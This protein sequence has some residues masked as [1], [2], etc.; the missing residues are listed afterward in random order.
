MSDLILFDVIRVFTTP[1]ERSNA[2]LRAIEENPANAAPLPKPGEAPSEKELPLAKYKMWQTGKRLRINF[3]GGNSRVKERLIE[4]ANEWTEYANLHFDFGEHEQSEIRISFTNTGSWSYIG[5][6]ALLIPQSQATMNFGWLRPD[7]PD[8]TYSQ[9]VLHEFGHAIGCIHEHQTP[10]AGVP[11]N[12]GAVYEFYMGPP[13]NWSKEYVDLNIFD[14]YSADQTNHSEFDPDSIMVYP[15]PQEH[16]IGDFEV[17]WSSQLSEI[18][19]R[20]IA[21]MYP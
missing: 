4:T 12:K 11:W 10:V 3:V 19:K 15:I 1:Q 5:T 17:P 13:N 9:V 6:D 20:F 18:D 14:T 21:E 16:T 8:E 2:E 7:S